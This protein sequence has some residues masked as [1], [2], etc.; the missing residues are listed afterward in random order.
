M[1]AKEKLKEKMRE[2]FQFG[3]ADLDF[4]IYRILNYKR[5][6]IEKF[7]NDDLINKVNESLISLQKGSSEDISKDTGILEKKI[8][9]D[10]H[11][12]IWRSPGGRSACCCSHSYRCF[13]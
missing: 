9:A 1:N 13:I 8:S 12:C 4:G 6:R 7:I 5:D 11:R 10:M 2:L 3:Q